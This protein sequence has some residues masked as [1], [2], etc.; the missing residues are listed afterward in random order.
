MN[1]EQT[2]REEVRSRIAPLLADCERIRSA[3]DRDEASL[4]IVLNKRERDVLRTDVIMRRARLECLLT[5]LH[6]AEDRIVRLAEERWPSWK[7]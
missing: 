2:V 4:P 3:I 6:G 1:L 7:K 5:E